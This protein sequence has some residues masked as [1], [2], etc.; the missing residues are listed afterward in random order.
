M[1]DHFDIGRVFEIGK[2]DITR[3]TCSCGGTAAQ[4]I[5][6]RNHDQEATGSNPTGG[7]MLFPSATLNFRADFLKILNSMENQPQNPEFRNK[8]KNSN[9]CV[10]RLLVMS[11]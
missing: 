11:A 9:L 1:D 3:L 7:V 4:L 10:C 8:P 6:C 5:E 2:F